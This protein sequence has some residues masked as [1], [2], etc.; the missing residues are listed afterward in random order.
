[1]KGEEGKRAISAVKRRTDQRKLCAAKANKKQKHGLS[2]CAGVD[3]CAARRAMLPPGCSSG[4]RC[5]GVVGHGDERER[6]NRDVSKIIGRVRGRRGDRDVDKGRLCSGST[7]SPE[8]GEELPR[9]RDLPGT[10][11]LQH[12]AFC[13]CKLRASCPPKS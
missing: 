3:S 8:D 11:L 12:E 9:S 10:D 13:L 5:D 4:A 2:A 6:E 1:M 7:K